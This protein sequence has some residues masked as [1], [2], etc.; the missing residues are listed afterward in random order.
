[1]IT[2]DDVK[3]VAARDNVDLPS[4]IG[5]KAKAS[6]KMLEMKK[7]ADRGIDG[8]L[9]F[10]DDRS[11]KSKQIIF[12]VKAGHTNV[13]HVRDLR[14]VIEREKA[15]IGVL[16]TM[17]EVTKPMQKEAAEAGFYK[18]PVHKD[19]PRIQLLS[20][21][22]LLMGAAVEYPRLLDATF[23]QAPKARGA[24]AEN[25]PLPLGEDE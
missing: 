7:G 11:G 6:Y 15:E 13:V 8:R 20:I 14:G 1:M 2:R 21:A 22:Q 3:S 19:Y 12:S 24:A 16:I 9:F 25:L 4:D 23:K 17:E 10:H 5:L 18:S